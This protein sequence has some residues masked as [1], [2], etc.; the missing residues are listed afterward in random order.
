MRADKYKNLKSLGLR[1]TWARMKILE[2]LEKSDLRHVTAEDLYKQILVGGEEIGL[3]TV[4]RVLTQFETAGLVIRH[5]FNHGIAVYELDRGEHHDHML[6]VRCGRIAEFWDNRIERYLC[7]A[8]ENNGFSVSGKKVDRRLTLYVD[9]NKEKCKY[10]GKIAGLRQFLKMKSK[11]L[12]NEAGALLAPSRLIESRRLVGLLP[13]SF[14][15][16]RGGFAIFLRQCL[17]SRA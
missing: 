17:F 1:A 2:L 14:W 4:Y 9:C 16:C 13:V 15:T 7:E 12:L 6:C 10:L 3:A 11:R 5:H 8:A